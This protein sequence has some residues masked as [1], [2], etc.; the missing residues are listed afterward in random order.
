MGSKSWFVT[1]AESVPDLKFV[2]QAFLINIQTRSEHCFPE[3]MANPLVDNNQ[4][5][6][7]T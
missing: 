2:T 6:P 7:V 4:P 1:V 5:S 3:L